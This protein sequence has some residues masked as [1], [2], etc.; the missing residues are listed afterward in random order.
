MDRVDAFV[1]GFG[2]ASFLFLLVIWSAQSMSRDIK[3]CITAAF[4]KAD[5]PQSSTEQGPPHG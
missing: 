5:S 1:L 2:C 3:R 4:D